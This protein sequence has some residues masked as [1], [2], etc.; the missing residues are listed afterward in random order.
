MLAGV[1]AGIAERWNL[2]VTL[3]RI[4]V[5][6]LTVLSGVGLVAYVAAWL[7]TPSTDRSAPLAAD[8]DLAARFRGRGV[9]ARLAKIA[10]VVIA[11]GI[12]LSVFHTPWVGVPIGLVLLAA[13]L[14]VLF[15]TRLGRWAVGLVLVLLVAVLATVGIAG[16]HLGSRTI[17]VATI[18]DLRSSYDYG[19][20]SV[21]LDLSG[22]GSVSGSYR[23]EVHMG[24][25]NVTITLP[26]GVPILVHARSGVGAV[27]VNGHRVHGI[28]AEQTVPVG[29]GS[30]SADNRLVVD[31][32]VGAGDVT[33]R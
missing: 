22:I 10:L 13:V 8:G 12:V 27:T 29:P 11:A 7:L 5:V 18:D 14:L 1:C 4:S 6:V 33:V 28:D 2:D 9:V 24:R 32:T 20:G 25:G 30:V 19:A 17:H 16:P 15:G 21:K 31:V 23:T 26:S 3:V